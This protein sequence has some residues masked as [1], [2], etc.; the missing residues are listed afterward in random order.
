MMKVRFKL[1]NR[2]FAFYCFKVRKAYGIKSGTH[3]HYL[4]MDFD[5][6]EEDVVKS[7]SGVTKEGIMRA[8]WQNLQSRF[9]NADKLM[10]ETKHGFHA[11]VFKQ[12]PLKQAIIEMVKT[13]YIDLS[14]VAIGLSRGYWFLETCR[15][16]Y[17]FYV[18]HP[19]VEFM[20][21]ERGDEKENA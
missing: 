10:Y 3:G 19:D 12:F 1:F 2:V 16:P 14:H 5:I 21:I 6:G 9:P 11:I 17:K 7:M 15:I 8:V 20:V 4:L 18:R 13:P